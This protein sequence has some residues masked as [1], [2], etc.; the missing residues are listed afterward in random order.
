[1]SKATVTISE[2]AHAVLKDWAK[3]SNRT[4]ANYITC[5]FENITGVGTPDIY[6]PI[7]IKHAKEVRTITRP[8]L[9]VTRLDN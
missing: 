6:L 4:L 8:V 5:L 1:M 2:K 7:E 9:K 3:E